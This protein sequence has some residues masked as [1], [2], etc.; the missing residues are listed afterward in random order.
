MLW[1][2]RAHE[3]MLEY[4]LHARFDRQKHVGFT[5]QK[6]AYSLNEIILMFSPHVKY[7]HKF[8]LAM[9]VSNKTCKRG[10]WPLQTCPILTQINIL[11]PLYTPNSSGEK[12]CG[13]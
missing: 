12:C 13:G 8:K 11:I 9:R 6:I 5:A 7:T 2:A 1:N 3:T 10:M 4:I